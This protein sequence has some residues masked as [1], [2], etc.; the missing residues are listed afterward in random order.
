MSGQL[1]DES[2]YY[3]FLVSLVSFGLFERNTIEILNLKYSI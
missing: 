1:Q 2:G 3:Y